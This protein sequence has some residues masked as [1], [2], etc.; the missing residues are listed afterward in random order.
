MKDQFKIK[1]TKMTN[2]IHM[3]NLK[4]PKMYL[5]IKHDRS[6]LVVSSVSITFFLFLKYSNLIPYL[7]YQNPL[8]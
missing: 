3:L 1:K 8:Q 6:L 5:A 2:P 7:R 4:D